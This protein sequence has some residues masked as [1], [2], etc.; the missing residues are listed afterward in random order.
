[1]DEAE[2]ITLTFRCPAEL[3]SLIPRPIPAVLGLPAWYKS[4]PQTA[5]S[6]L[7]G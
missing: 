6:A 7:M 5:V 1:M 2:K 3:E 4:L